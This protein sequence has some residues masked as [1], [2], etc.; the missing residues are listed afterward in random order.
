MNKTIQAKHVDAGA[1]IETIGRIEA[2]RGAWAMRVDLERAF[3]AV[4]PKV[5]LA[6]CRALIKSR[7]IDGCGCGCRGDFTL[8]GPRCGF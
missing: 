6:K 4:P 5:L 1:I 7:K 3:P 2:A 8:N